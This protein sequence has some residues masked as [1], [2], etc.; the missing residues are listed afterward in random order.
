VCERDNNKQ[1]DPDA[2][3]RS[4]GLCRPVLLLIDTG[5][6]GKEKADITE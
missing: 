3:K 4:G 6:K 1:C 2:E 5:I